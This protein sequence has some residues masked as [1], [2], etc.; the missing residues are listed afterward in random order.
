MSKLSSPGAGFDGKRLFFSLDEWAENSGSSAAICQLDACAGWLLANL[1]G[2]V[3]LKG[4]PDCTASWH[5]PSSRPCLHYSWGQFWFGGQACSS[6]LKKCKQRRRREAHKPEASQRQGPRKSITVEG[7][8]V[9][10]TQSIQQSDVGDLGKDFYLLNFFTVQIT[11]LDH[12]VN[13]SLTKFKMMRRHKISLLT[14]D[15]FCCH[16]CVTG[17][18]WLL[19]SLCINNAIQLLLKLLNGIEM[20]FCQVSKHELFCKL[21][22]P[23]Q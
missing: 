10:F 4:T 7:C 1:L 20:K 2:G 21:V 14:C 19:D 13:K 3:V 22:Q 11:S 9:D 17:L 8:W 15:A 5:P 18:F 23:D 6:W 12:I 16:W